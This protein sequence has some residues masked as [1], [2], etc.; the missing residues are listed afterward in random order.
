MIAALLKAAAYVSTIVATLRAGSRVLYLHNHNG[1]LG[2]MEGPLIQFDYTNDTSL[3]LFDVARGFSVAVRLGMAPVNSLKAEETTCQRKLSSSADDDNTTT[4]IEKASDS[5]NATATNSTTEDETTII[6]HQHQSVRN[7]TLFSK[8]YNVVHSR[9]VV[10]MYESLQG[11]LLEPSLASWRRVSNAIIPWTDSSFLRPF[12]LKSSKIATGDDI[13]LSREGRRLDFNA[14]RTGSVFLFSP[15]PDG[16]RKKVLANVTAYAPEAFSDLRY[17]FDIN[18][19]EFFEA[20]ASNGPYVSFQSNSKGAARSGGIFFFS[21]NGAYMVKTIKKAEAGTF[22]AMLPRYYRHMK[23]YSRRS[24]LTRFCGMYKVTLRDM[25]EKKQSG[26]IL[27]KLLPEKSEE[28]EYVFV[29]MNSVYPAEGSQFIAERFDLKG[30]TVGRECSAEEKEKKRNDAVLKDL[31][32]AREVHLMK[33][34]TP[35]TSTPT[36]GFHIGA[37]LKSSLLS[38]LRKDVKFLVNCGVMDYSLL[39]GVVDMDTYRCKKSLADSKTIPKTVDN[40]PS[41]SANENAKIEKR[42]KTIRRAISMTSFPLRTAIAP[43][44]YMAQK[45]YNLADITLS[46]VLTLPLPYYGAGICGVDGGALSV[47]HGRRLGHRCVYYVGVIDFLQP[48]TMRKVLERDLKGIAGY[49]VNA[50]SCVDPKEYGAR[51]LE[52]MNAHIT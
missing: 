36:H 27:N 12:T 21:K 40:R 10:D 18:E 39:V 35:P 17:R 24:L 13:F 52:Y 50:I 29:I 42:N 1:T 31:D 19:R 46:S 49:D 7:Q 47:L 45:L 4:T 51:F 43:P 3:N 30:S 2:V 33:T 32:L 25:S 9:K 34:I 23:K 11:L 5:N 14:T 15:K 41:L 16:R 6:S 28:E 37:R 44:L 38:Q 26:N 20:L 8:L 22:L 48:W